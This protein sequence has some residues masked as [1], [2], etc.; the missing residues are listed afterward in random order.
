METKTPKTDIGDKSRVTAGWFRRIAISILIVLSALSFGLTIISSWIE[1]QILNANNWASLVAPIPKNQAVASSLSAEIVNKF[2][3]E[4]SVQSEIEKTLPSNAAPLAK[5]LTSIVRN[6]A[7]RTTQ[8]IVMS[9]AFQSLWSGANR[10][11]MDTLLSRARGQPGPLDKTAS[12]KFKLNLS[13]ILDTIK[14]NLG[15][16]SKNIPGLTSSQAVEIRTSLKFKTQRISQAVKSIDFLSSVLPL[17]TLALL[18]W[19]IAF[20]YRRRRTLMSIAL[21]LVTVMLVEI[22]ALHAIGNTVVSAVKNP[23]RVD[24]KIL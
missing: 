13:G 6:L 22:I 19:T 7:T 2:F 10:L 4:S 15:E 23:A 5:P 17:V 18:I 20:S 12:E 1:N 14:S 8:T 11:A 16:S 9:N 24:Y 21:A 3:N